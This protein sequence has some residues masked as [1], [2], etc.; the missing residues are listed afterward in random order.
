MLSLFANCLFLISS[1]PLLNISFVFWICASL[2]FISSPFYFQVLH[3]PYCHYSEVSFL[4]YVDCLFPLFFFFFG[5][6]ILP[7]PFIGFIFLC[8][9]L[10]FNLLCL[11]SPLCSLNGCSSSYLWS[12]LSLV[13]VS[14]V[15]CEVS[16]CWDTHLCSVEWS[17]I[18]LMC[19]ATTSS[20]F[21]C[22]YRLGI[23]L[24][25]LSANGQI[26]VCVLLRFSYGA[27]SI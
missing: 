25:S 27:S 8:L 23:A 4:F 11:T 21:W 20:V 5:L 9:F 13:Q 1:R 17:W 16:G 15:T 7:C 14:H 22:V 19:S 26:Y 6:V 10:L 3:H 18:F 12:L 24:G 2:L